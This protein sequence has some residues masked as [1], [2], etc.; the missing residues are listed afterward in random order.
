MKNEYDY[1]SYTEDT[2]IL[3]PSPRNNSHIVTLFYFNQFHDN[4]HTYLLS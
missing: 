2:K 3:L 1:F 4:Y